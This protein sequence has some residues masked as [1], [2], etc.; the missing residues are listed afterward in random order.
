MKER[1]G[2]EIQRKRKQK[3]KRQVNWNES[4]ARGIEKPIL[5]RENVTSRYVK[6]T[7]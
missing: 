7:S 4:E 2:R 5:D 1:E 3:R 6:L